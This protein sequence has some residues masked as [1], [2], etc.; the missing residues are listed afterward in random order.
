[1]RPRW[2]FIDPTGTVPAPEGGVRASDLDQIVRYLRG[3]SAVAIV[4]D[5]SGIG[6]DEIPG[7]VERLANEEIACALG[8]TLAVDEYGL[9][10]RH[11]GPA[12]QRAIRAGRHHKISVFLLSQR[13]VDFTPELRQ[14]MDRLYI[15]RQ[16]EALDRRALAELDKEIARVAARLPNRSFIRYDTRSG[17][18][19]VFSGSKIPTKK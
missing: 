1:M 2:V 9:L 14:A 11:K 10:R 19:S 13:A 15:F 5:A 18:W 7:A 12:I 16:P 17:L 6:D 4:Y 3:Y 8:G